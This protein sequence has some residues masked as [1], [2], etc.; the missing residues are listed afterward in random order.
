ME[1]GGILFIVL[2]GALVLGYGQ[3]NE[4]SSKPGAKTGPNGRQ[5]PNMTLVRDEAQRAY[6]AEI[7]RIANSAVMTPEVKLV[8]QRAALSAYDNT[9]KVAGDLQPR[10]TDA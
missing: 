9:I 7:T 10:K 4:R 5:I 1:L 3:S 2:V 8:A 6:D